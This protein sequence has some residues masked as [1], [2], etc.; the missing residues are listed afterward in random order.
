MSI[1]FQELRV[2][3]VDGQIRTTDVTN[4]AILSAM[5][6]MPREKFVPA[7]R[8]PLAYID[9]DIQ[10]APAR[11]GHAARYLMEPSPFARL[12]QLIEIRPDDVILD[13]GCGTGYSSA[14]LSRL[15]ASVVA[16]ESD[17][18]LATRAREILPQV[19]CGNVTVV[20]GALAAGH[21]AGGP[22]DVIFINGAVDA[23][24]A[25]LLDQLRDGGRLVAVIGVGNAARA[26]LYVK[27]EGVVSARHAF[28]AALRPLDEF[29]VAP[30]FQ[31]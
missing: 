16:L 20:E 2:K 22:Y 24:P 1:D 12:V 7:G 25:A 10:I 18:E 15:G 21:P 30:V 11:D 23:V 14:I 13:V 28:N 19:E 5:L 26:M 4:I 31:F 8:E 27:E 29:R 9:E 6:A 3:M 17:A